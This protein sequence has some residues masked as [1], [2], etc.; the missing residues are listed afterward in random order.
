VDSLQGAP[1]LAV[2]GL[3]QVQKGVFVEG[4]IERFA[5][6]DKNLEEEFFIRGA[7]FDLDLD[8]AQE[9]IVDELGRV[10]V[11]A[12]DDEQLEGGDDG[13]P[14]VEAQEVDMA[15]E[16]TIQRLSR[17]PGRTC[18]RPKSSMRNMPPLAFN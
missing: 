9:G 12:E 15:F 17:S 14:G 16:G 3:E 8:A 5:L 2:P 13:L 6:A 1:G 4:D 7:D 11:G 18:W 10:Q